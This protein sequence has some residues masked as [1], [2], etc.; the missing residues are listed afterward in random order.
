M[1]ISRAPLES[2]GGRR[3]KK[4]REEVKS[5]LSLYGTS[6]FFRVAPATS[7]LAA[8]LHPS[9][10]HRRASSAAPGSRRECRGERRKFIKYLK[11]RKRLLS[12][13]AINFHLHFIFVSL[14]SFVSPR[15]APTLRNERRR[16]VKRR[17]ERRKTER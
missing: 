8:P 16:K 15:S 11:V 1:Y 14:C 7:S 9:A 6:G 12:P 5:T 3:K 10:W 13:G 2:S 17:D 4:R